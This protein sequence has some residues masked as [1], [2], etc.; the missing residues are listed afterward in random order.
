[1]HISFVGNEEFAHFRHGIVDK[2][3]DIR[4]L[5]ILN[6]DSC[7]SG[8]IQKAVSGE[9][10]DL[11]VCDYWDAPGLCSFQPPQNDKL[12]HITPFEHISAQFDH[13]HLVRCTVPDRSNG[14][15][16]F[17]SPIKVTSLEE[18]SQHMQS[19]YCVVPKNQAPKL[20]IQSAWR[21]LSSNVPIVCADSSIETNPFTRGYF[22]NGVHGV[23]QGVCEETSSEE[24][25]KN[26]N[27]E[28]LHERLQ[29]H[30][31]EWRRWMRLGELIGI[32]NALTMSGQ[33]IHVGVPGGVVTVVFYGD[34][35]EE[36]AREHKDK[37][38]LEITHNVRVEPSTHKNQH[39]SWITFFIQGGLWINKSTWSSVVG[40]IISPINDKAFKFSIQGDDD[41][42]LVRGCWRRDTV[43]V[44]MV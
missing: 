5:W 19:H 35:R 21:C 24:L 9:A 43:Q 27:N 38:M 10:W 29:R 7:D 30:S 44:S 26:T 3:N 37:G 13:I 33:D 22:V 12:V 20:T 4:A 36:L 28:M 15:Y 39:N 17:N 6:D 40:Q 42:A 34:K 2:F 14:P 16:Y 25:L 8:S 11:V 1:M 31:S 41:F 23:F 18:D 32:K